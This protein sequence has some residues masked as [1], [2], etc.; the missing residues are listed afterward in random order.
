[1]IMITIMM[2]I[3]TTTHITV[4]AAALVSKRNSKHTMSV[5]NV[6][7]SRY[8]KPVYQYPVKNG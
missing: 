5:V 4:V 8:L 7:I 2:I 3:I 1:M 6:K